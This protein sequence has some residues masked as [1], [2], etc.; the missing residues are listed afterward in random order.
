[1]V[2]GDDELTEYVERLE[3]T[4]DA[5]TA[6]IEVPSGEALAAEVERFLREEHGD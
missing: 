6:E 5:G 2:A 3:R 4:V 1:V